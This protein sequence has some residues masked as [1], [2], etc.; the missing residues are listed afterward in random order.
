[1]H[2]PRDTQFAKALEQLKSNYFIPNEFQYSCID[3][4]FAVVAAG[5]TVSLFLVHHET[6]EKLNSG[7]TASFRLLNSFDLT[8]VLD[9]LK[10]FVNMLFIAEISYRLSRN[11]QPTDD[12]L[13]HCLSPYTRVIY[14]NNGK[15]T[16]QQTNPS[17][18]CFNLNS[19]YFR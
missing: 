1:M 12:F 15:T 9:R 18:H 4:S 13:S 11:F 19:Y 6:T 7:T 5:P 2:K 10:L 3:K 14:D 17:I 16:K 8:E